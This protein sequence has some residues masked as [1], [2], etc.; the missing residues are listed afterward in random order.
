MS[1]L[2]RSVLAAV[3]GR[4]KAAR[5]EDEPVEDLDD[6]TTET[7]TEGDEDEA[8]VA[9]GED[10]EI[11][12]ESDQ[13]EEGSE[14]DDPKP[15]ASS[16]RVRRAEQGRIHAILT[17]PNADANPGLASELAFGERFYSAKE[18]SALL[19]HSNAGTGKLAGRMAGRSPK[20]GSG[21][22]VSPASERQSLVASVK[23]TIQSLHGRKPENA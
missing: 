16:D 22:A 2:T 8:P 23:Q 18:A 6:E 20:I 15:Q 12:A 21:G 5:L 9:E 10:E 14:D 4:N 3:R 19:E 17:H 11:G 13:E 1:T 7:G